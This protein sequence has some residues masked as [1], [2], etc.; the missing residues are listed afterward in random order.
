MVAE[1][2]KQAWVEFKLKMESLKKQRLEITAKISREFDQQRI[3][4]IRK[5]LDIHA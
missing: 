1:K 5:E 2:Y 3:E 4:S